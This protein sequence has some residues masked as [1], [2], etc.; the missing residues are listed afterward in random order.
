M[1][2]LSPSLPVCINRRQERSK[3][4][5]G[6]KEKCP[7]MTLTRAVV[8][9]ESLELTKEGWTT[10]KARGRWRMRDELKGEGAEFAEQGQT[11]SCD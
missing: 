4:K 7:L 11:L 2:G 6:K 1:K 5:D 10:P 3:D 9:L 8:K